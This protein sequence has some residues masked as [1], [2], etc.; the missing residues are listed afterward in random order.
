MARQHVAVV[1]FNLAAVSLLSLSSLS[2]GQEPRPGLDPA[3]DSPFNPSAPSAPVIPPP[4]PERDFQRDGDPRD[5]DFKD[6]DRKDREPGKDSDW[7]D[8]DRRKHRGG[9][10]FTGPDAEKAREAFRNMSP[11]ERERWT[12]RIREWA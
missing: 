9:N 8:D 1:A 6:R 2:V 10:V 4:R 3:K 5:K 7:K 11:E 12:K